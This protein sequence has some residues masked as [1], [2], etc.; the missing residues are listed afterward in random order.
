MGRFQGPLGDAGEVVPDGIQ[1]GRVL[2]PAREGSHGQLR[3]VPGPVEPP[4]PAPCPRRRYFWVPLMDPAM[5]APAGC[6]D[7]A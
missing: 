5:G 4:V 6:A 3:V 7:V 1:V 2:Q